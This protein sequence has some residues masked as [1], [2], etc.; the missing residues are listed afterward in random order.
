MRPARHGRSPPAVPVAQSVFVT[1]GSDG[2]Y[3]VWDMKNKIKLK[4][5]KAADQP[6][7]ACGWNGV[8]DLFAYSAS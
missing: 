4:E 1:A 2:Y 3:H 7:T 8:G 5:F 6:L